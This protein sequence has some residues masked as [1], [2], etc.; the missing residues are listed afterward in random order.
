MYK[1]LQALTFLFASFVALFATTLAAQT[2]FGTVSI[3]S[4]SS[5]TVPVYLLRSA[6]L[7]TISVRTK[8][9]ENKDFTNAG[10]GSCAVGSAYSANATCTVE[11]NF[12]PRCPGVREGAVVFID[13][14]GNVVATSYL[15]GFGTGPEVQFAPG[16]E[17]VIESG[18]FPPNGLALDGSGN[19][20]IADF[21]DGTLVKETFANGSYTQSTIA[22]GINRAS[23]VA[24]DGAGNLFVSDWQG[25]RVLKEALSNG[26]YTESIIT[27]D[28]NEPNGLAVDSSGNVYITDSLNG[29]VLKMTLSAGNYTQS[30]IARCGDPGSQTCSGLALD[31]ANNVYIVANNLSYILKETLA[32]GA[33]TE[34]R[35]GGGLLWPSSIAVDGNDN[36]YIADSMHNRIV[37]ETLSAGTYKASTISSSPLSSPWAVAVDDSSNIYISD[38][39]HGRVLKENLSDPPTLVFSATAVGSTSSDSPKTVTVQNAGNETLIFSSVRYPVDFPQDSVGS[40]SGGCEDFTSV[41]PQSSCAL[42]ID[43]KPVTV[44]GSPNVPLSENVSLTSNALNVS[45]SQHQVAVSGNESQTAATVTLTSSHDRIALGGNVNF[46]AKVAGLNGGATPT[47]SIIFSNNNVALQTVQLAG[48][49]ASFSTTAL[50]E[51]LDQFTA[52][53]SGDSI[54][55]PAISNPVNVVVGHL[56]TYVQLAASATSSAV[57]VPVTFTATLGYQSGYLYPSG[58]ITF[59]SGATV[60]GTSKIS[61]GA[62]GPIAKLT[63]STLAVGSQMVAASYAGDTLFAPATSSAITVVISTGADFGSVEIGQSTA[64]P[65]VFIFP[66]ATTLGTVSV[67]TQG[68][69]NLDFTKS[70]GTCTPGAAYAA[71]ATCT[72]VANFSPTRPGIRAGAVVLLDNANNV[73]VT[74]YLQGIGMGPQV[75]FTPGTESVVA[76]GLNQDSGIAV[77]A[78]GNVFIADDGNGNPANG[79]I[80]KET[81]GAVSYTQSTVVIGLTNNFGLAVD[82]AGNLYVAAYNSGSVLKQT[83]ANGVYTQSVVADGLNY[84]YDLA[85]DA[86]GNVYIT[87]VGN[88]RLLKETPT[89][90]G[91]T[92]TIPISGIYYI[93]AVAVDASGNIYLGD[94]VN[95]LVLKETFAAGSYTESTIATGLERPIGIAVDAAGNVYIAEQ[96]HNRAVKESPTD[97]GYTQTDV[98]TSPLYAPYKVAVDGSGNLYIADYGNGRVLKEDFADPPSLTFAATDLGSVSSDSPKT[99]VL[100]NVGNSALVIEWNNVGNPY[101]STNFTWDMKAS[102]ACPFLDSASIGPGLLM[103]G[104]SCKLPISYAPTQPGVFTGELDILDNNLLASTHSG[105]VGQKIMLSALGSG[106]ISP[107][108][109]FQASATQVLAGQAMTLTAT[110]LVPPGGPT[111]TGKVTFSGVGLPAPVVAINASGLAAW[112]SSS[113][114]VGG[115]TASATYSGD[116]NYQGTT[117]QPASFSI[118]ATKPAKLTFFEGDVSATY[119]APFGPAIAVRVTDDLGNPVAGVTVNFSGDGLSFTPSIQPSNNDGRVYEIVFASK[120]GSMVATASV[121][122]LAQTASTSVTGLP[123]PLTVKVRNTWRYYGSANP[124]FSPTVTGLVGS[125]VV[126]IIPQTA[127][128]PAS[129]VGSYSVSAILGGPNASNYIINVS[130]ATLQVRKARLNLVAT[131]YSSQYGQTPPLPTAYS[132]LG[133]LNGDTASVVS[134][135]PTLSTVVTATTPVGYYPFNIGVGTLSAT[136]YFLVP[137]TTHSVLHVAKAPLSVDANNLTMHRGDP[138]PTLT[139]S[140]NGFVNGDTASVVTGVPSIW[141]DARSNTRPG[142]YPI[143]I[144]SGSLRAHDYHMN[145][146]VGTLTILP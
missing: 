145:C 38:S 142:T 85:V 33:Y 65:V 2:D 79:N 64:A 114:A 126:T 74:N 54:Y 101:I 96:I 56:T 80:F 52:Q 37:K 35:I 128:T 141:T 14:G 72:V 61:A 106:L 4:S 95:H 88:H 60:L 24:I 111:P 39:Y 47:G 17:I 104:Q 133:L 93:S 82:G 6:T 121:D 48:G 123:A 86:T 107:Q 75:N 77:D 73:V 63:T 18:S 143:Y 44:T 45:G 83:L 109:S 124:D 50:P 49:T 70:G 137:F 134:G 90:T 66:A 103:A 31:S 125:D 69:E 108:V 59:L 117:S 67:R 22:S 94:G 13:D 84:P 27:T 21:N 11:V 130:P 16:K 41:D 43:F 20:F 42:F 138:L 9:S 12:T 115:Y 132:F 87:D 127:A 34:S 105:Y 91:Y 28:V 146:I 135:S 97:G 58:T 30:V 118:L 81:P 29:R 19:V 57:G 53:Y 36:L 26:V 68:V 129:P 122:G 76:S 55:I 7:G 136:N 62:N 3:A 23:G 98:V 5:A 119:G 32:A 1:S 131:S 120:V 102:G 100:Q 139:Y 40:S 71:N 110:V 92:Q 15:K 51:G 140:F 25:N 112:T 113:L 8:G 144:S 78:A 89:A 46:T 116:S 10:G 99:V